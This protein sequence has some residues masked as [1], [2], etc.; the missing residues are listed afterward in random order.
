M[1]CVISGINQRL[2]LAKGTQGSEDHG[3][4]MRSR[5]EFMNAMTDSWCFRGV[6]A[7][8]DVEV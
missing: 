5:S 4:E 3:I 2:S 8:N 6:F 7:W 1:Y